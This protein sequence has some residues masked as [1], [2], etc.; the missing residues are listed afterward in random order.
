MNY[1]C[2][3]S[4]PP[5]KTKSYSRIYRIIH[6]AIAICFTFLLL[7][8]FLRMTWL[9]KFNIA[10]IIGD[11][12][13]TKNQ[14]LSE[15][16][17][18]QLGKQIRKPMWNWHIYVGYVLTALFLIRFTLPILGYMRFQNPLEHHITRKE[19][20]QRWVYILFYFGVVISLVTGLIIS[21]GPKE[22]KKSMEFFHVKSLFYLIP[23]ILLHIGGV[24]YA[25]F[26]NHKGLISKIISGSKK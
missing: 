25:E 22:Y 12:L 13:T 7:T 6:W 11:F 15:E 3:R 19:K 2:H 14:Q 16:E 1:F 20:F 26:T 21:L 24:L 10:E 5:M 17:L 18:I 4:T 8:I 23:F 9:N